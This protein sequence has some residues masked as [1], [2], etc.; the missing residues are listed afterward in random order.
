M[1][2]RSPDRGSIRGRQEQLTVLMIFLFII[3]SFF[4]YN[5]LL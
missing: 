2:S 5:A 4:W 3:A 1:A